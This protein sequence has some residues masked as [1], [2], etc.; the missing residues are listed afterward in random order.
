MLLSSGIRIGFLWSSGRNLA[1][2][3]IALLLVSAPAV[4]GHSAQPDSEIAARTAPTVPL[5]LFWSRG[6]PH[7]AKAKT[8][9]E[10]LGGRFPGLDVRRLELSENSS[11]ELAFAAASK[12]FGVE[13]PAVPLIVVGEDVVVGYDEDATTGAKIV[14]LLEDCRLRQCRDIVGEYLRD[15]GKAAKVAGFGGAETRESLGSPTTPETINIALFGNLATRSLSLPMLTI[16]LGAVDGFNPCAMWVLV[17][18]IGLLVG[19]RDPFR[20][21]SYGA[22]F[23]LTSGVVYF[24]F[25]EAWL[26]VFLFLGTLAW[27]RIGIGLFALGAATYYLVQFAINPEAACPVAAPG[28]RQ[29]VMARLKELVSERSFLIA[30]AGLVVLA[31]TVN[32]IELLCSAGIP[33]V[34]TQVLAMSDLSSAAYYAYITLYVSVFL[35]DDVIIFVTAMVTLRATELAAEYARYSH[36]IGGVALAAVGILLLFRPEWLAFA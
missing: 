5:Y 9:V 26:N 35:L 21:W 25:L 27:I 36:L 4:M 13:P 7:C 10:T 32:L 22:I 18:L 16:L 29:R 23:L 2:L 15:P 8:F 24:A 30:A 20:M 19:M 12:H 6:C 17:F 11:H 33:A 1:A 34:Y 28:E 31:V 14:D 3:A